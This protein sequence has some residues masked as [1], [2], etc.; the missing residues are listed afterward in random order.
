MDDFFQH[1]KS[2]A[3]ALLIAAIGVWVAPVLAD[4]AA[5]DCGDR[6]YC[7]GTVVGHEAFAAWDISVLPDGTGLPDGR[8]DV[9]TGQQ[10]YADNC[11]S[12]HGEGGTGGIK[13][14][15]DHAAYPA[16]VS[17]SPTPLA[18]TD[19]WPTKNV[20]TYWPYATTVFDY[21]RR[22]M[23]FTNSQSLSNDEVY[24]VVAYLLAR[25]NIIPE[26]M[27]LIKTNLASIKMPN[28]NGF[29]CDSR[30]DTSNEK[31]MKNCAVPGDANFASGKPTKVGSDSQQD[32]MTLK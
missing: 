11:A 12:C 26:D 31:C 24:S 32:C 4:S 27:V 2:A 6:P 22:A 17:A 13:P 21:V 25:N 18:S 5:V 9:K 14:V 30:P 20:G 16:L 15:P 8:G 1:W 28:R 3:Q 7:L 29:S 23:P 10:V 19:K